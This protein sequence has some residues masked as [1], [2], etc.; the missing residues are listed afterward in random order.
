LGAVHR[1]D[2]SR[3]FETNHVGGTLDCD[4]HLVVVFAVWQTGPVRGGA[5]L[6][7]ENRATGQGWDDWHQGS[8]QILL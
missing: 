1:G 6:D 7:H 4:D 2:E 3:F 8:P 5:H